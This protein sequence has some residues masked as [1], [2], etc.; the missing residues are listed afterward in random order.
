MGVGLVGSVADARVVAVHIWPALTYTC[1]TVESNHAL[2][3]RQLVL[4][5]LERAAADLEGINLSSVLKGMG[6]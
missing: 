3:Y 1:V 4:S 5:N 6:G 2:G